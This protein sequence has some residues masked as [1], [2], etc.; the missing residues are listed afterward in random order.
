MQ[1]AQVLAGYTLGG[2]DLLRRAMGK[3]KPEE[4]ARQRDIFLA[5][6]QG[7]GVEQATA[8]HI[9]DLME[10]FAGYGFNRS[11]SAAYALI[12]YQ[13]AWLKAHYAAAFMAAVLS[14]DMDN[15]DKVVAL[16]EECRQLGLDVLPPDINVSDYAFSVDGERRIL[17]GLGAIKGVGESAVEAILSERAAGGA[18]PDMFDL[19]RRI[20]LRRAN[21]RVLEALIRAGALDGL[22]RHRAALMGQL[23]SALQSAEQH[24]RD[25]AAGQDDLFG[26]PVAGAG[27]PVPP[28]PPEWEDGERLAGEKDTLGL[29]LTGHPIA[30]YEAELAH[31]VSARIGE[32]VGGGDGGGVGGARV[33]LREDRPAVVA[34][35]VVALRITQT[36]RGARIAFLTLDDRSG[37][38]EIAVFSEAFQRFRTLLTKDRLLVVQGGLS[39]DEYTGGY[40]MSADRIWDIGQAR[41]AFLR[42]LEVEVDSEHAA[43]GFASSL[44]HALAPF[45]VGGDAHED[46]AGCPVC[47]QYQR[48]G[49]CARIEFGSDW[50]VQPTDELLHRLEQLAGRERVRLVY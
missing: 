48:P 14:A 30:R 12:S 24:T 18:F 34:G 26:G 11:H 22:G 49:A 40:R 21:R 16:I 17:Y 8:S 37:R 36:Q 31:I 45:R 28:D 41:A 27:A 43:N 13:T 35:L 42:R 25:H 5:G 33:P 4:M 23:T 2:A 6:A 20:D 44:A 3:K 47:V 39:S 29:Y 50:R 15:T 19:C 32:L 38:I 7:R 46:G 10:K 1:I 9:F